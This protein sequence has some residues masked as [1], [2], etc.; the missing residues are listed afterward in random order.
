ML[1]ASKQELLQRLGTSERTLQLK[2][3]VARDCLTCVRVCGCVMRVQEL[4]VMAQQRD[5]AMF[6]CAA[7]CSS[8]NCISFMI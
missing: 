7:P 6:K 4:C 8:C 1:T 3:Q 2:L 5:M